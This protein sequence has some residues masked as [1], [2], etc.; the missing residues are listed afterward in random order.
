MFPPPGVQVW[1]LG[2]PPKHTPSPETLLKKW[3]CKFSSG[4]LF[5]DLPIISECILIFFKAY[6]NTILRSTEGSQ[7][8]LSIL[9]LRSRRHY[10]WFVSFLV[11]PVYEGSDCYNSTFSPFFSFP[12]LHGSGSLC[13]TFFN[14]ALTFACFFMVAVNSLFLLL[15]SSVPTFC[16]SL[17][18]YWRISCLLTV[19]AH[20]LSQDCLDIFNQRFYKKKNI[21]FLGHC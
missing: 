15:P 6:L 18:L 14:L 2:I 3:V 16:F 10:V 19:W 1:L 21:H 8:Q 7:R 20:L 4:I 5:I 13:E 17:R 11:D 9:S 12:K